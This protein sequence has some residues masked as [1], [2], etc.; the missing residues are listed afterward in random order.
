MSNACSIAAHSAAVKNISD[1]IVQNSQE[2]IMNDVM[3]ILKENV[4]ELT[5]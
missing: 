4:G 5:T 3:E 1:Y 2:G